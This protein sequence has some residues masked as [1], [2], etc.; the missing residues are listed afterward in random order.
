VSLRAREPE[1]LARILVPQRDGRQVSADIVVAGG[2][3]APV[4]EMLDT[5]ERLRG[6][7]DAVVGINADLSLEH[8]LE[9][10]VSAATD[11]GLH[12]AILRPVVVLSMHPTSFWG[13]LALER[14]RSTTTAVFPAAEVPYVSGGLCCAW[15]WDR[16]FDVSC[17]LPADVAGDSLCRVTGVFRWAIPAGS[18]SSVEIKNLRTGA[19]QVVK[20]TA[21]AKPCR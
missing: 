11:R 10:I 16:T 15:N 5:Q 6:L 14:A 8:A 4:V 2:A 19:M 20:V 12:A 17:N 7:F 1:S 3:A 18:G 13:P 9:R 21:S